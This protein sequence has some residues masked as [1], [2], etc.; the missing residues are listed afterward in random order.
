MENV[1]IDLVFT[2]NGCRKTVTKYVGPRAYCPRCGKD[3]GPHYN[4]KLGRNKLYGHNFQAWVVYQRLVLRLPYQLIVQTLQDQFNQTLNV[5]NI[6]SFLGYF[7]QYYVET[8]EK[9]VQA[10]LR[11]PFVHVDETKISIRGVNHYVWVFTNGTHVFFRMTATRE[12]TIVHEML[13]GYGG[14]LISDFYGGYD[15]VPCRQ[16]KCLVHLIRDLNDD[17]WSHP[18]DATFEKLV[19]DIGAL[20]TPM[21]A[22]VERYGLKERHLRKHR[23][24][25]D[26]FY[27]NITRYDFEGSELVATYV[28]RF[29]RYRESLFTFLEQDG[30]PWNNNMAERALRHLAVQRKISGSFFEGAAHRYLLLL[31]LAQT[32]RFQRI[33]LLKFFV[34]RERDIDT[35]KLTKHGKRS[36]DEE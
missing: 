30:I 17:L 10:V 9:I 19:V 18:F 33:S 4:G 15:A 16:Q 1:V 14:V 13:S 23:K 22:D 28:K 20:I 24:R 12:A 32:C 31:G 8:E 7:S 26:A 36:S 3:Y 29:V 34:S 27:A 11:S 2:E 21:L 5:N 6:F 35:F 25:V